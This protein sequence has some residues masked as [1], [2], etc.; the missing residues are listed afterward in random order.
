MTI[1]TDPVALDVALRS[2]IFTPLAFGAMIAYI[3][4]TGLRALSKMT[5]FDFVMTVAVG[6]LLASAVTA[7]S[8][9]AF[10]Q[11][12][13]SAAVLFVTQFLIARVRKESD[14][15][16]RVISNESL[17]LMRDGTIDEQALHESRVARSDLFAK[18]RE[19]NV[20]RLA[21]VQAVVLETTG[22]ISVLHGDRLDDELLEGVRRG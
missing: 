16:E 7:T 10:G 4:L 13:G 22:D 14:V 9:A 6:S 17:L 20:L 15:F 11:A 5:I 2:V 8:W 12:V 1:F 19:A 18:L 21:D 3:R